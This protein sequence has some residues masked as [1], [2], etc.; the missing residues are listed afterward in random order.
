[1]PDHAPCDQDR[2]DRFDL[3]PAAGGMVRVIKAVKEAGQ[4]GAAWDGAPLTRLAPRSTV[5]VD[6]ADQPVIQALVRRGYVE[7]GRALV[8]TLSLDAVEP[9][10]PMTA[11]AIWPPL[12]IQRAIWDE[13]GLGPWPRE[14][15]AQT[16]LLA[17]VG[18]RAAGVGFVTKPAGDQAVLHAVHILPAFRGRGAGTHLIR[19]AAVW[20][21]ENGAERLT[22]HLEAD[23]PERG[24]LGRLGFDLSG[25][26]HLLKPP[27]L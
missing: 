16:A 27:T 9:P 15:G 21:K 8:L 13:S 19:R 5:A 11:F 6:Q 22:L 14:N 7:T 1:M 2:F 23:H 25:M 26:Y 18:D 10:R 12:A 24:W 4:T 3:C 20:A 17:R